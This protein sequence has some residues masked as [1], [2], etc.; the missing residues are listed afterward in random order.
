MPQGECPWCVRVT[1]QRV[2]VTDGI[3]PIR[4]PCR[5]SGYRPRD[6][7]HAPCPWCGSHV[8]P[9]TVAPVFHRLS[10]IC[11]FREFARE[12]GPV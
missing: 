7:A 3:A 4:W 9:F 12:E 6:G 11:T 5:W 8:G 2:R 10:T 1:C